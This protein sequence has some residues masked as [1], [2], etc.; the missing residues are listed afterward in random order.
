MKIV[1]VTPAPSGTRTG[2][3]VTAVR[4]EGIL[5][6]LGCD[7][8]VAETWDGTPCDVLVALHARRSHESIVRFKRTRPGAR[9]V[10]V[11][12]GTDLYQ[13]LAA[14]D[15]ARE[16]L[17][18][19]DRLVVLQPAALDA[20]PVSARGKAAVIVQSAERVVPRA[21]DPRVFE[22]CVV[23]H[24][25]EVKDP[26]RAAEAAR[27]LPPESRVVVTHVGGAL[28][29]GMEARARAE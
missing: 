6:E 14:S 26:F 19:A 18:L 16:S 28:E 21:P 23:G 20:L 11:L 29:E 5:R 10:V 27:R 15:E 25:R 12:T 24:L 4:W 7:V 2:N 22:V 3:R 13:D 8:T 9:L 17:D 1:L